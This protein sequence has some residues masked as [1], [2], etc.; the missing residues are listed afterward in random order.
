MACRALVP[1]LDAARVPWREGKQYDNWER[2]EEALFKSLVSEPCE[3]EAL[4]AGEVARFSRYGFDAEDDHA[5]AKLV[6]LTNDENH[7]WRYV[8]LATQKW[9][10]D[11]LRCVRNGEIRVFPLGEANFR[12]LVTTTTGET[13]RSDV[14]LGL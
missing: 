14:R 9:P 1:T 8:R 3:Y 11:A 13:S 12:F 7:S 6:V 2:L 5:N 4:E 10:F